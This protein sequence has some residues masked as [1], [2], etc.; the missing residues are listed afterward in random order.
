[1][2]YENISS[3]FMELCNVNHLRHDNQYKNTNKN[4]M[5]KFSSIVVSTFIY[6]FVACGG[7]NSAEGNNRSSTDNNVTGIDGEKY[8]LYYKLETGKTYNQIMTMNTAMI[9]HVAGQ[10]MDMNI[11]MHFGMNFRVSDVTGDRIH[12]KMGFSSIEMEM[13]TPMGSFL[14]SSEK[15]V[16]AN[17]MMPVDLSKMLKSMKNVS[18]D[19]VMTKYG[20]VESLKG[21]DEMIESILN[22]FDLSESQKIQARTALAQNF[23]E[24][25]MIEQMKNMTIYP[26]YPVAI[27]ESWMLEV[28]TNQMDLENTYTLKEITE[29]EIVLEVD[30]K[31][32]NMKIEG[33]SG[34]LEGIQHGTTIAYRSSG[35]IKKS[36]IKQEVAGAITMQGMEVEIDMNSDITITD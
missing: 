6:L 10:K 3:F 16:E 1:M 11:M 5:K 9:Q 4:Q 12:A 14:F 8:D 18:F 13:I 24:E 15:D 2:K 23:S 22:T 35:W 28:N 7:G 27:G 36:K 31:I 29:N 20:K 33:G 21:Y 26:A 32:L 19:M 17:T 25:K 30:S 34:L